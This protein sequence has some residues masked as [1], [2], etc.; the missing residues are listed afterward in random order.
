MRARVKTFGEFV[1]AIT[2]AYTQSNGF[3]IICNL[4]NYKLCESSVKFWN[5][6]HTRKTFLAHL[7]IE[8][9]LWKHTLSKTFPRKE[10]YELLGRKCFYKDNLAIVCDAI[11][12]VNKDTGEVI[13]QL[14]IVT[15]N[16]QH[17]FK[18]LITEVQI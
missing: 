4:K 2:I 14:S 17:P 15:T 13:K 3:K 1:K 18:V 5:T 11:D 7:Y 8:N 6:P 10:G 9:I 16:R 12:V